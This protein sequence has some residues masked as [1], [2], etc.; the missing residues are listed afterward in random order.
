MQGKYL[1]FLIIGFVCIA[2]RLVDAALKHTIV[3]YEV[4]ANKALTIEGDTKKFIKLTD[5]YLLS[6]KPTDLDTRSELYYVDDD[7][8][9]HIVA[10]MDPRKH[11]HRKIGMLFPPQMDTKFYVSGPSSIYL[12]GYKM[13]GHQYQ[14]VPN[15]ERFPFFAS[16][17]KLKFHGYERQEFWTY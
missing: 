11:Y 2:T 7:G 17:E 8:Y 5:A 12:V 1:S 13:G 4:G 6:S 3:E 14:E 15:D 16:N 9:K 10:I